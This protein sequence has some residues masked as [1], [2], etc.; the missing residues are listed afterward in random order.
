MPDPDAK[1]TKKVSSSAIKEIQSLGMS[2]ALKKY[3]SGEGTAE[4]KTAMERYYSPQRLKGASKAA[5]A[6]KAAG[7]THKTQPSVG[8]KAPVTMPPS[9]PA[10][11]GRKVGRSTGAS[12]LGEKNAA[13]VGKATGA[14]GGIIGSLGSNSKGIGGAGGKAISNLGKKAGIRNP[15]NPRKRK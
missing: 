2:K 13:A 10:A 5:T 7:P 12:V 15:F 6:P 1:R 4:F 14:I 3:T 8:D 9:A 11:A